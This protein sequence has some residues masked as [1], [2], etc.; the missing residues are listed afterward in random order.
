M[1]FSIFALS[2][3]LWTL[4]FYF[5]E[6]PFF[7]SSLVWIKV[8]YL[9]V[10]FMIF[11]LSY[12]SYYF[13]VEGKKFPFLL[14]SIYCL[15]AIPQIW[16]LLFTN[17]W[18]K[19]VVNK[20]WG[21]ATI[22]GPAYIIPSIFWSIFTSLVFIRW[23][24]LYRNIKGIGKMQL[25]FVF[26]GIFLF[27][28]LTIIVDAVIPF[29]TGESRYF[30]LSPVFSLFFAGSTAY[31]IIRYRLM[32][33]RLVIKRGFVYFVSIIIFLAVFLVV[34]IS[35]SKYLFGITITWDRIILGSIL[36][37]LGL[38]FFNQIL[39][40]FEKLTNKYF[41]KTLYT[42]KQ[43]VEK[44][45]KTTTTIIELDKL[46]DMIV[47]TLMK[48]MGLNRAGVLLADKKI[49][50]KAQKK[51]SKKAK[52]E[53][54]LYRIT[55]TI[56]F[57]ETNGISLVQDNFLTDYLQKIKQAIVYEEIELM[58]R[59]SDNKTEKKHLENLRDNMARIE[60]GVCLPLFSQR[61]LIGLIVLGNKISG[62][63]YTEEDLQLLNTL[64]N[65]ASVAISNARLYK[66]VE[67]AHRQ[68]ENF[69]K[70]LQKEVDLATVELIDKNKNLQEL[71]KMKSEFLT[72]ASHQLR[73]PTS[74]VRG[75]LSML[76][77]DSDKLEPEQRVDFLDQAFA[78]INHLERIIR[79]LLSATELEGG[80][81][82]FVTEP[83]NFVEAVE[84][85]INE[86]KPLAA[87]KKVELIHDL[88][89]DFPKILA[90]HYK[91]EEVIGNLIDNGIYYTPKGS[92]T[93]KLSHDN[94]YA[95]LSVIDTGIG[96][97]KDDK[98]ILF[99]RFKRGKNI[100]Q[101]HPN[102]SGLGLYIVKGVI[103]ALSGKLKVE[104]AGKDK[105][106]T[107]SIFL[108]LVK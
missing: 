12:F 54:A 38:L 14:L 18:I 37:G 55:K 98:K 19:D 67:A 42:S 16:L 22:L 84:K 36:F 87:Q 3:T 63:A 53:I 47:D 52:K 59:D 97:E 64:A 41:F 31:A 65:Q 21:I 94:K 89:K 75:I 44:L 15:F 9:V 46:V 56:G 60:A 30:W 99:E 108:P 10:F 24:K 86:R 107:F 61:Q 45:T 48:S 49:I 62:E 92:V 28:I 78:S 4:A 29:M 74:I 82:K 104:S 100:I 105:G 27:I 11:S 103:E 6:H 35:L 102:G 88:P 106:S 90:D 91:L 70:I 20:S 5:Y 40:F 71:L 17:L 25:R 26:I 66:E 95:K 77:E 34:F 85:V 96:I 51:E 72:I 83:I 7:L 93:I 13:P 33:I 57:N 32:D 50:R 1:G 23:I 8:I 73:T 58:I 81:M 76:R 2:L 68:A 80:K 101:I 39:K 69:N 79:D 43:A